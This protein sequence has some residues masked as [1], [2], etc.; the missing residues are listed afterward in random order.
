MLTI[1]SSSFKTMGTVLRIICTRPGNK[2]F[3]G[4]DAEYAAQ[5]NPLIKRAAERPLFLE[6]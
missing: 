3:Q 6:T 2:C 1:V 4:L 5:Y